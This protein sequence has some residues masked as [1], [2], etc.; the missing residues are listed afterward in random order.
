MQTI[1]SSSILAQILHTGSKH[2]LH[3]VAAL[4]LQNLHNFEISK[5]NFI[6]YSTNSKF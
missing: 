4:C 3:I 5:G 6:I 2:I 1:L